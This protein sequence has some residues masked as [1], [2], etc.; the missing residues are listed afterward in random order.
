MAKINLTELL[1]D[2]IGSELRESV[3]AVADALPLEFN[4]IPFDL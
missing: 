3:Y 1:G 2:G 4:F